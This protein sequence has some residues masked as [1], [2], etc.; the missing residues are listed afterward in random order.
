MITEP[1]PIVDFEASADDARRGI[2]V[3]EKETKMWWN[4]VNRSWVKLDRRRQVS[5]CIL[6]AIRNP[7]RFEVII[8]KGWKIVPAALKP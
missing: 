3:A 5:E 2:R 1:E 7:A 8:I 4:S 6:A